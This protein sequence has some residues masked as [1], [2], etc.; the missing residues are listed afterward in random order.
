VDMGEALDV[1]WQWQKR[2]VQEYQ[3]KVNKAG[4]ESPMLLLDF[5]HI[6]VTSIKVNY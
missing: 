6:C 4:D 2:T 1:R 5:A 3:E